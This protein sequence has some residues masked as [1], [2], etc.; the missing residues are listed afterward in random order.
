MKRMAFALVRAV[1]VVRGQKKIDNYEFP[2]ENFPCI[3]FGFVVK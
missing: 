1:R 3:P 2:F